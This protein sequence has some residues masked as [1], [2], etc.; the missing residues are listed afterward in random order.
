[1]GAN[2]YAA[3]KAVLEDR[4]AG[5]YW[6]DGK[7][8][9]VT[10]G[11]VLPPRCVRCNEPAMQ[12][13]KA[14]KLTYVHGLWLLL[15]LVNIVVYIIVALIVRKRAEVTYGL[16]EQHHKRR[17]LFSIIGWVGFFLGCAAILVAPLAGMVM[18]V[19]AILVGVFGSRVVYPARITT[20]EVRLSG[21]GEA[22]LASLDGKAEPAAKVAPKAAPPVAAAGIRSLMKCPNCGARLPADAPQ[23]LSCKVVMPARAA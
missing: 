10:P 19:A 13:M 4:A 15:I 7:M 6:R 21:C 9:V 16:C 18:A 3:P 22:F 12:P 17:R 23:C 5:G 2:P 14:H 11:G 20:E 1:M 8:L